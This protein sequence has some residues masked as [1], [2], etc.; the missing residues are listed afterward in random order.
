MSTKLTPTE[1]S[2]RRKRVALLFAACEKLGL[3]DADLASYLGLTHGSS[4]THWRSA[5]TP[6]FRWNE[7]NAIIRIANTTPLAELAAAGDRFRALPPLPRRHRRAARGTP[8]PP[9]TLPGGSRVFVP[10]RAP[11]MKLTTAEFI[12][13]ANATVGLLVMAV[14]AFLAIQ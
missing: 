5:T 9:F 6:R 14:L 10:P 13:L 4:V 11:R 2:H 3:T 1:Y 7:I 12:T 8:N